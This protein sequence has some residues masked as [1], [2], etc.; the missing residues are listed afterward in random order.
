MAWGTD[1]DTDLWGL[2]GL[3]TTS[4]ISGVWGCLIDIAKQYDITIRPCA[5]GKELEPYGA[6]CSGC[7]TVKTYEA[8]LHANLDVPK[9]GVNQRGSDCACLLGSDIGAYDTCGHLCRYCY[10]NSNVGLV[11]DNMRKHDFQSL[12]L[13][14][15]EMP[16]DVIH[17]VPQRSWVDHQLRFEFV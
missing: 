4:A 3:G 10:A 9:R 16:G 6:D 17:V 15:H 5:E 2:W 8:A 12:F 11:R 13:I 1:T 14:G 7:M